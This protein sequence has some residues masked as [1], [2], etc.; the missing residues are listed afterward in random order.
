MAARRSIIM[1]KLKQLIKKAFSYPAMLRKTH[2][3]TAISIIAAT[4]LFAIHSLIEGI[5]DYTVNPDEFYMNVIFCLGMS[6]V[7]FSI[8]SLCIES[9][10]PNWSTVV[11]SAVFAVFGILSVIMGFIGKFE[12]GHSFSWFFDMLRSIEAY[13]G[14][15]TVTAFTA[16]LVGIALLMALY[17]SYSHDIDQKFNEHILN[18][19][20]NI[21]FTS[22]IYGVIQIGVLLL[23]GIVSV[24]LYSDAFNYILPVIVL[25]NGLFYVPAVI[26]ALIKV[27]ERASMFVQILV[28]YILLILVL[29]AYVIIYIYMFKLVFTL[30]VPS[31]S[32]FEILTAL[33]VF[34]MCVAYMCTTFEPS[35]FLQ[36]IAINMPLIFAPF[37]IMQVYTV[38]VRIG[39]YGVT[40]KRYF[41]LIFIL[42][43]AVYIVVY[44]IMQ[45]RE[46]EIIGRNLLLIMCVFILVS[47]FLPGI[48]ARALSAAIAK[49]TL[50]SYV[51][52]TG[53][54]IA[55]SDREY[56]RAYSA[57]DFLSDRY[58][59]NSKTD[60]YFKDLGED[61]VATLR[62]KAGKAAM[63]SNDEPDTRNIWY[64]CSFSDITGKDY[65]DISD[66]STMQHVMIQD[67]DNDLTALHVLE[68]DTLDPIGGPAKG[69]Y[70]TVNLSEYCMSLIEPFSQYDKNIITW[71]EYLET[72]TPLGC[73]DLDENARLYITDADISLE[74]GKPV[75]VSIEGY[76]FFR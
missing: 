46:H 9:I 40:P 5:L 32:V 47:V 31:N 35:G 24:L 67:P 59:A 3:V 69:R 22:I 70:N 29:L 54:G 25:I 33:F 51:D 62:E 65:L 71:E 68:P 63:A 72:V 38:I 45:K 48:N 13:M 74:D 61:A 75:S 20:S 30:S 2:P 12:S 27:N 41:G 23:T 55:M 49:R 56:S 28:R 18:A 17:F 64:S 26:M 50:S 66:Y 58:F 7:Y 57:Y 16:G 52:K 43:E 15:Y 42:F 76:I 44:T 53:A 6:L 36:K 21:F 4:I 11:R 1:E 19:C 10:R 39:Q 34:S 8:F 14:K 60:T 37:I 73:I